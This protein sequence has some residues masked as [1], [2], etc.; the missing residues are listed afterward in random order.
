MRTLVI[1]FSKF[2]NTHSIAEAIAQKLEPAMP[3]RLLN[4]QDL[5]AEYFK[6]AELVIMGTP[7]H[8]MN[9]PK[10]MRPFFDQLPK[11]LLKGKYFAAFDTSYKM[12]WW[13]KQFTAGKRLSQKLRKLGG[14]KLLP[15]EIFLVTEREGPLYAGEI[16]R[17][18]DWAA[19]VITR[20]N[21]AAQHI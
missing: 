12:S 3:V 15:P 16:E 20:F 2:G 4:A 9:L 5:T 8:N 13:L 1:Y 6:E 17:A 11:K 21:Q 10:P 14:K 7:T 18:Q 19:Q